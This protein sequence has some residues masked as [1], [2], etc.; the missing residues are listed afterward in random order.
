MQA[1][2]ASAESVEYFPA[3]FAWSIGGDSFGEDCVMTDRRRNG[4][5]VIDAGAETK[6]V[7]SIGA[8]RDNLTNRAFHHVTDVT[9]ALQ[10]AW[11]ELA[12]T[13]PD[14]ADVD[15][16]SGR[17]RRDR[18]KPAVLDRGSEPVLENCFLEKSIVALV[19]VAGVEPVAGRT[20]AGETQDRVS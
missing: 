14:A 9:G 1:D 16:G 11:N 2:F 20:Q 17:L 10:F 12:A 18:A 6:P 8:A 7:S 13:P 3:R 15:C 19:E 5:G 4:V